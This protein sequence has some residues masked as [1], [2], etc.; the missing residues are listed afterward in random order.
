VLG[1]M[2]IKAVHDFQGASALIKHHAGN[3]GLLLMCV[4]AG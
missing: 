1:I 2:Q 3:R 4:H